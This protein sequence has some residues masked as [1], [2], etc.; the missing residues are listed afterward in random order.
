MSETKPLQ[1]CFSP[2]N[3][4]PLTPVDWYSILYGMRQYLQLIQDNES[5]EE[6]TNYLL[7]VLYFNIKS[8]EEIYKPFA[9]QALNDGDDF[10]QAYSGGFVRVKG[11]VS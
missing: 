8:L 11:G 5:L 10:A 3:H 2:A 1:D 7:D 9:D 4:K 6:S